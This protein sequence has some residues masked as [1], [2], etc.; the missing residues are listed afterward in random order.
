VGSNA[1]LVEA[2]VGY[3]RDAGREIASPAEARAL[4]GVAAT[5]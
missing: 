2:L 4:M 3:A 5:A 1:A